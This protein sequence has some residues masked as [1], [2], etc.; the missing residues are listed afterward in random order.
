MIDGAGGY[1]RRRVRRT[2][3]NESAE[4]EEFV[5]EESAIALVYNDE[6][7]VVM[8]GTPLDLEDFALGF[9][10]SEGVITRAQELESV[11]VHALERGVQVS[12]RIPEARLRLLRE[13]ERGLEG[14]SSCGLCG[15]RSI[16]EVL[17]PPT[18]VAAGHVVDRAALRRALDELGHRQVLNAATGS[19]HAAAW[20]QPNG[21]VAC[22]REDVGRHNALDKLIGA[23]VQQRIDPASGFAVLTSRASYEMVMKAASAGIPLL[24]AISAPTS[25]AIELAEDAGMTL[26]GFMR[27][28]RFTIYTCAARIRPTP[29]IAAVR[30][31]RQP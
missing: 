6:P 31:E 2:V 16:D 26:V 11:E 28:E 14:R 17:R 15:T 21:S 8:M 13:R 23:L 4:H 9:S 27:D 19:I 25:L 10:L 29:P 20:A 5:A 12:M 24:A 22:L 30:R 1:R 18:H 3:G 7:H